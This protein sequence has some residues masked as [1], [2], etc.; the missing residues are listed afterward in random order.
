M[1]YRI[2]VKSINPY[3]NCILRKIIFFQYLP[4]SI[5]LVGQMGACFDRLRYWNLLISETLY[6]KGEL[7]QQ[8]L[9]FIVLNL[10]CLIWDTYDILSI[11]MM[12]TIME[13][14]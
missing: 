6:N 4:I 11:I 14:E 5:G 3:N 8:Y 1:N 2:D 12:R 9:P 13:I 10:V 7:L